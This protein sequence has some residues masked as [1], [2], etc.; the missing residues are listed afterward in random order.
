[1]ELHSV[2]DAYMKL[3][4]VGDVML[5]RCVND[6][7][8]EESFEHPWGDTLDIFSSADARFCN[9]ECVIANAG[10]PWSKTKKVFHFRSDAKN[11]DVLKKATINCVSLANNHI[12]DYGYD[13]LL[14][15]L[16]TLK[17][18]NINYAGAGIDIDAAM[19]P[20]I[21]EIQGCRIAFLALT[22][23]EPVWE[24]T[25]VSPGTFF[26]PISLEDGRYSKLIQL[27]KKTK[28]VVDL[29]IISAHWGPNW[30]YRPEPVHIPFAHSLIENG[31]DIIFGHSC[32]IF[33]GVEVYKNRPV[34]YSAG[35]FIDDYAVDP[36]ERNDQSFIFQIETEGKTITG[37]KLY[38]TVI[39][40][41]Q[42]SQAKGERGEAIAQHMKL[43][44][45]EF[46]TIVR[47][48]ACL[49]CLDIQIS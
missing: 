23:N 41:F 4:F 15:T 1:M 36:E 24:A 43:L 46:G 5:G 40:N 21:F 38:P 35:D 10:E 47:W 27:I 28:A 12:L 33:Q 2:R 30:G 22:D 11:V 14:E 20:A 49:R 32:H 45:E 7:L 34:I 13:A 8:K 37:L 16:D 18:E 19:R 48:D 26:M 39:K 17:T 6:L 42:A 29:L 44:C 25:K 3:V 31:A 9:L